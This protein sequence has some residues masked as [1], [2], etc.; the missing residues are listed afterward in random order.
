MEIIAGI[1]TTECVTVIAV[2]SII[3]VIETLKMDKQS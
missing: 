1:N 2:F 3:L